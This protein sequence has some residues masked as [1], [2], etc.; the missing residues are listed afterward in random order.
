MGKEE[1]AR[2]TAKELLVRHPGFSAL[3]W[4]HGLPYRHPEH[5]EALIKPLKLAGLPD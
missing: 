5:L 4:A 1:E 3:R 2:N